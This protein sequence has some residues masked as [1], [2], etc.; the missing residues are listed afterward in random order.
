MSLVHLLYTVNVSK[1]DW[2]KVHCGGARTI[3]I[4]ELVNSLF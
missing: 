4:I 3:G 2:V 1:L